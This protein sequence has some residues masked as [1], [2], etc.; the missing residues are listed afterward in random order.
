MVYC[1]TGPDETKQ[2]ILRI[3]KIIQFG[4]VWEE[5]LRELVEV[6][7]LDLRE[8]ARQMNV[9]PR[10]VRRY[11]SKLKLKSYWKTSKDTQIREVEDIPK[12]NIDSANAIKLQHREAWLTLQQEHPEVSKT[13]LRKRSP[14]TYIYLYRND[15]EWLDQNSPNL[16][17]PISRVAKVNWDERD[18]QVL[19]KVKSAVKFLLNT[20]KPTRISVSRIGKNIGSLALIEKHLDLMPLT[21]AY[22]ESVTETVEEF[23]IRRIKWAIKRLDD[24]G[25][26]ILTWKVLRI[27]GLGKKHTEKVNAILES[28]RYQPEKSA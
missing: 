28:L 6:Q 24:C 15:R 17:K 19:E 26:D 3:G 12:Q 11:V 14:A 4:S 8:I 7:R 23:Q 5:K 27:A 9:D 13:T 21:K 20:E 1:R 10:T 25:E 16:R 22:F 2:D 18:E